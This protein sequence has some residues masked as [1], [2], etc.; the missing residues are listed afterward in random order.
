VPIECQLASRS[1]SFPI[2]H[3]LT[4][5]GLFGQECVHVTLAKQK[6]ECLFPNAKGNK[7]L[8][9]NWNLE[10]IQLFNSM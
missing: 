4:K 7:Y 6:S 1:V 5:I 2:N 8:F 10:T 9:Q 3:Y